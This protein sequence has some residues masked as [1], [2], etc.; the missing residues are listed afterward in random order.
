MTQYPAQ[1]SA[2]P[3]RHTYL[4]M[5]L[6]LLVAACGPSSTSGPAVNAPTQPPADVLTIK[7]LYT[8][9]K[10]RWI[11]AVMPTFNA[12][13]TRTSTGKVV[14]VELEVTGSV[15]SVTRIVDGSSQPALWSPASRLVIPLLNDD[16]VRQKG[17]ELV[18]EQCKDGVLSPLVIMMWQPFAEALGWPKQ[19]VGWSDIAKLATSPNGWADY[20]KPQWGKFRF[21]HTHPDYSNSGLQTIVAMTYA[22]TGKLRGLTEADVTADTTA[23]FIK[24]IESAVAHYGSSTGFF[25]TAMVERGPTYLSAAAVYE[26]VVVDSYL[27]GKKSPD[28]FPMVAL[29]PK[30]GTFQTDHPLCIPDGAWMTADSREAAELFRNF[31]LSKPIQEQARQYGFRPADP[32]I[33]ITSPIDTTYG[34]DATQPQ[35]LLQVPNAATIRAIRQVWGQQKRQ[36]NITMLIDIS[37][38]MRNEDRIAGARAGAA[39][40]ISQLNDADTLTIILFDDEQTV[41][42]DQ[43]RV[44]EKREEMLRE[45]RTILPQGGTA[46]LDSIAFS[47]ERMQID[48]AKINA[49]VVMTDGQDTNSTRYKLADQL[50]DALTGNPEAP[51]SEVALFTIGY[52]SDADEAVLKEIATRGR[53]A[54]FR[55]T[56]ENIA[57]VYRDMST[58]F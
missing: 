8:S 26:S 58:F 33:P 47:V 25:G 32:D 27:P 10:K 36:V 49:L 39:A 57:Q 2:R 14:Q 56:V 16:W 29:Y 18:T 12:S 55:G 4:A 6:M 19:E 30:E 1:L 3:R 22:A 40:F 20:G 15:E 35:N 5:L 31:L 17:R 9:E 46:L 54:Y 11:E 42:F 7:F 50:M 21:G 28:G 44:G 45:V 52:G 13:N 23:A 38:S 41:L 48:P 51:S 43:V 24:N 37:G 53:G 34:V